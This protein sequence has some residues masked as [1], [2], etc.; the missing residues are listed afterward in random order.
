MRRAC[1][2]LNSKLI[3]SGMSVSTKCLNAE[4]LIRWTKILND[5]AKRCP[6]NEKEKTDNAAV[7]VVICSG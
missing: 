6:W 2:A 5:D 4:Y 3:P 7:C 1:V